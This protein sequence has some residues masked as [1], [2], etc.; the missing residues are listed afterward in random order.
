MTGFNIGDQVRVSD[1]SPAQKAEAGLDTE[2]HIT[3]SVAYVDIAS[4]TYVVEVNGRRFLVQPDQL[5]LIEKLSLLRRVNDKVLKE[6]EQGEE[7]SEVVDAV[8]TDPF[9][10]EIERLLSKKVKQVSTALVQLKS[11][12]VATG[13]QK[14]GDELTS[15]I[16]YALPFLDHLIILVG[17]AQSE[18]DLREAF[19]SF[20]ELLEMNGEVVDSTQVSAWV[21]MQ[22]DQIKDLV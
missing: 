5:H 3:G 9:D 8:T 10:A 21:D 19:S 2:T 14:L 15:F 18:G 16:N 17:V 7:G 1:L 13:N 20:K 6:Q 4:S 22:L 11:D 12:W